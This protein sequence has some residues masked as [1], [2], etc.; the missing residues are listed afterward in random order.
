M[1]HRS[2]V[3]AKVTPMLDWIDEQ[4]KIDP[5]GRV[6]PYTG[7]QRIWGGIHTIPLAQQ[8]FTPLFDKINSIASNQFEHYSISDIWSN[9]NPPGTIPSQQHNHSGADIAGCYYLKVPTDSG[10]IV[11][12][13]GDK[14]FPMSGD[15]LWWDANLVHWVTQNNSLEN[16]YTVAFNITKK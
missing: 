1:I 14:F 11:F 16:R 4:I 5:K 15:I 12:E 13:T 3:D 8:E 6:N 9:F 7:Q 10:S 2:V